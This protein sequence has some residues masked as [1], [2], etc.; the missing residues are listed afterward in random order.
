M[1]DQYISFQRGR[2]SEWKGHLA[3]SNVRNVIRCARRED[4]NLRVFAVGEK[5]GWVTYTEIVPALW[6]SVFF[7]EPKAGE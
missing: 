2:R 4:T 3:K 5:D 7:S 6:D 1:R